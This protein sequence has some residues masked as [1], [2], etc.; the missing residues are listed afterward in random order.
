MLTC[1]AQEIGK[2]ARTVFDNSGRIYARYCTERNKLWGTEV[3][4]DRIA[5]LERLEVKDGYRGWGVGTW[6]IER[7]W[8]SNSYRSV[9]KVR[10]LLHRQVGDSLIGEKHRQPSCS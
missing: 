9:P 3:K 6:L 10:S 4:V 8:L 7:M 2:L 5:L 1:H